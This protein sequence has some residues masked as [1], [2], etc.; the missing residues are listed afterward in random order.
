MTMP[1]FQMV[2]HGVYKAATNAAAPEETNGVTRAPIRY[3]YYYLLFIGFINQQ[4]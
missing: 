2:I 1:I 4:T 3:I